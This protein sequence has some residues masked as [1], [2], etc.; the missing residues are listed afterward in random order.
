MGQSL[1]RIVKKDHIETAFS[2]EGARLYGGRWNTEGF[3]C[4]YL[5][6]T[7]AL[8]ALEILVHIEDRSQLHTY[9]IIEIPPVKG[10]RVPPRLADDKLPP[11]WDA[12]ETPLSTQSL[13]N[14]WL[15]RGDSLMLTLPSVVMPVENNVL[16]NPAHSDASDYFRGAVIL[17]IELDPRLAD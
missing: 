3:A 4:V 2:G 5:A 6:T 13:G 1:Y 17:D 10:I 12:L 9:I 16:V 8:A 14:D 7:P 15:A 11:N